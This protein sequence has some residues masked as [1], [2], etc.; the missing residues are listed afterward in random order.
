MAVYEPQLNKSSD[1][2]LRNA[3]QMQAAVEEVRAI[4][5]SVIDAAAAKASRYVAKGYLTPRERLKCL[6]DPGA[7]FFELSSIAG[8]L[9]DGDTDGSGAGAFVITGIG[10]I[11]GVRCAVTVDNYLIKGGMISTLGSAKRLRLQTIC[12]E[13]KLPLVTLAQSGGG[14]LKSAGDIFGPSGVIFANQARLSATA[15]WQRLVRDDMRATA[16]A[17]SGLALNLI[18]MGLGPQ[19]VGIFSDLLTPTLGAK[20]LPTAMI[21][22][23]TAVFG[24]T[25]YFWRAGQSVDADLAA[26]E[27]KE[28]SITEGGHN[29]KVK[30]VDALLGQAT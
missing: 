26:K 21:M 27:R 17:F 5:Q 20:G 30:K 11:A 19:L 6:L 24:A 28:I 16:I 29:V 14:N 10:Y 1:H 23:A 2:F 8:Y 3:E 18:A 25:Y 9:Q 12:L 15:L 13:N 7:P 22:V 4:E